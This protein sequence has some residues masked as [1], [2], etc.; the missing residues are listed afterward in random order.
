MSSRPAGWRFPSR[1]TPPTRGRWTSRPED[2][3]DNLFEPVDDGHDAGAHGR[4]DDQSRAHSPQMWL[5]RHRTAAMAAGA[6]VAAGAVAG[7]GRAA[8]W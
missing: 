7:F 2:R 3:R 4:F 5:S 6:L 1:P 8:R